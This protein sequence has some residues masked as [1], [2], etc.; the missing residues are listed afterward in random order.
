MSSTTSQSDVFEAGSTLHPNQDA[1]SED[2]TG[3]KTAR[4]N[5][6]GTF[7]NRWATVRGILRETLERNDALR[8]R[9]IDHGPERSV[10]P[11]TL[12]PDVIDDFGTESNADRLSRFSEWFRAVLDE[13]VLEPLDE[14]RVKEGGHYTAA[15]V[16]AAYA[17]G[18]SLANHD[19]RQS[20]LP[21]PN[22]GDDGD[23]NPSDL[24][25]RD[26]HQDALKQERTQIYGDV[27][28]AVNETH[29][30]AQRTLSEDL[31]LAAAGGITIRE[32]TNQVV[33][34]VNAVGQTST[35]TSAHT[36][37]VESVNTAV[38]ERGAEVGVEEVGVSIEYDIEDDDPEYEYTT[39]G[40]LRVCGRCSPYE[41]TSWTLTEI[42]TGVGPN[43]PL[44]PRCRCR[45]VLTG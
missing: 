44:H 17:R 26:R 7:N 30:Q 8:L 43:P 10:A 2:P 35:E 22:T 23:E 27:N 9:D 14:E 33:G 19:L 24:V 4:K 45:V 31:S 3:T 29:T 11:G 34:R 25:G 39:A 41:G 18:L 12:R 28:R 20:S 36:R 21:D 32:L 37:I 15:M 42:R 1:R 6:T 16:A 5:A 13:H 40:D 38:I